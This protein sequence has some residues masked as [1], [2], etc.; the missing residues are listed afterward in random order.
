LGDGRFSGAQA[1]VKW[2]VQLV[3]CSMQMSP[4]CT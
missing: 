4:C 2:K 3:I 1:Q